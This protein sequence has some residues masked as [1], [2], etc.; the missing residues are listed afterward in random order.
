MSE[1]IDTS[2]KLLNTFGLT[3]EEGRVYLDIVRNASATALSLSRTLHISRTKVYRIVDSLIARG[4]VVTRLG[5]RGMRFD[6]IP[7]DQL[8]L[9]LKDREHELAKLRSLLPQLE[10]ELSTLARDSSDR[11][12]VLYYH[13]L[14]GLKQVTYN[15]L[16]AQGELLTYEISDM[17]AFLDRREAEE[18]RRLFLEHGTRIRTLTNATHLPPWTDI[19]GAADPAVWQIRHLPPQDNPFQFEILIYNDVYCMYRYSGDNIFCV[20][21]HSRE[22][23]DMQR[24][25]FEYLWS[26][27]RKFRVMNEHGEAALR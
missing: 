14:E 26:G 16:K 15:S 9:I 10:S 5:E 21:I 24:Q 7:P 12:K 4:L 18:F 23:A 25:L 1:K 20:E 17:N 19:P 27:A 11:S 22:L 3:D 13:G 8:S 6:S 2:L